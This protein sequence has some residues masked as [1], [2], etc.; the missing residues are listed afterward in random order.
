MRSPVPIGQVP[1]AFSEGSAAIAG[2]TTPAACSRNG[3][4]TQLH[5]PWRGTEFILAHSLIDRDVDD[6]RIRRN[7]APTA[8]A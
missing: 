8:P 7:V 4:E 5:L 6:P 2:R 1:Q 3:I